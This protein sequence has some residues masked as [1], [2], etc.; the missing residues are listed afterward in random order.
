MVIFMNILLTI[1]NLMIIETNLDYEISLK[2]D[3]LLA[4]LSFVYVSLHIQN[5]NL[6]L[7][8]KGQLHSRGR[9]TT[10]LCLTFSQ[11]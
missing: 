10:C 2:T 11:I 1:L 4:N 5:E 7:L 3:G 6:Y 8:G 9:T